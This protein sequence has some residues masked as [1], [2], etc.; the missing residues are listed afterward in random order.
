MDKTEYEIVEIDV[1]TFSTE[2]VISTSCVTDECP[3]NGE[4]G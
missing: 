4:I 1:M 3:L 2:D